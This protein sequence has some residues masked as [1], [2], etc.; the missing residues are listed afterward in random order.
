MTGMQK[1]IRV[2]R[3]IVR[4]RDCLKPFA[5]VVVNQRPVAAEDDCLEK[6][7]LDQTVRPIARSLQGRAGR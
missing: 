4:N 5:C 3:P 7:E 1:V 2:R 6:E